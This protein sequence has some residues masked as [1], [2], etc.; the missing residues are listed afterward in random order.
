MSIFSV[1]LS[2]F[3]SNLVYFNIQTMVP[4]KLTVFDFGVEPLTTTNHAE[5]KEKGIFLE[6]NDAKS[7]ENL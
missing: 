7:L 2:E 3:N 4:E 5:T 1:E 6:E